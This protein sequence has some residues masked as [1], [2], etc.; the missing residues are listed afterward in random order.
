MFDSPPGRQAYGQKVLKRCSERLGISQI[1]PLSDA[2]ADRDRLLRRALCRVI[3]VFW[4]RPPEWPNRVSSLRGT[5]GRFMPPARLSP[6]PPPVRWTACPTKTLFCDVNV[7]RLIVQRL[8]NMPGTVPVARALR[9]LGECLRAYRIYSVAVAWNRVRRE[10]RVFLVVVVLVLGQVKVA[11]FHPSVSGDR[12]GLAWP[13]F[14]PLAATS[15]V[16]CP[17]GRTTVFKAGAVCPLGRQLDD[18]SL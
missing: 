11:L 17:L 16:S 3:A 8:I 4:A 6:S 13:P 18:R 1:G 9:W 15:R 7:Q 10:L 14:E 12:D 2:G 5:C